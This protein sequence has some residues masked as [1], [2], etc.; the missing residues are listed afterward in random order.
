M[1]VNNKIYRSEK[2]DFNINNMT[3]EVG[4]KSKTQNQIA[5]QKNNA[6]HRS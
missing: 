6:R 2:G 4:G 5:G 3:F 1:R